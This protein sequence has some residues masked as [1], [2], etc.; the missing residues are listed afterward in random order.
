VSAPVQAVPI[1]RMI[2]TGLVFDVVGALLIIGI[3]PVMVAVTGTMPMSYRGLVAMSRPILRS[4][5]A[6]SSGS[7][8]EFRSV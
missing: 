7:L 5:A 6:E 1:N 2:R 4:S 8:A 3:V